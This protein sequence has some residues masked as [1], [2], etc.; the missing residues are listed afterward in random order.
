MPKVTCP[1]G[2]VHDLLP[3]PDEG[4]LIVRDRDY[5]AL[6]DSELA[7]AAGDRVGDS[8]RID[9]WGRL[10]ECPECGRLM[11]SLPGDRCTN[12]RVFPPEPEGC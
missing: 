9:L 10:Y 4:W 2:Y 3:I 11:W 5:E 1:C 6:I 7:S 8:R 12:F